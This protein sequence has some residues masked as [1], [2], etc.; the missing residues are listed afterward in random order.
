VSD[1]DVDAELLLGRQVWCFLFECSYDN[2]L[3]RRVWTY[4]ECREVWKVK[5]VDTPRGRGCQDDLVPRNELGDSYARPRRL[6]EIHET[7]EG[8]SAVLNFASKV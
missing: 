1:L 2:R 5:I 8:C 3:S 4:R 6:K 7:E